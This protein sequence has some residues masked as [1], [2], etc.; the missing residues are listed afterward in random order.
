[1]FGIS[2]DQLLSWNGLVSTSQFPYP[3]RQLRIPPS[4]QVTVKQTQQTV[5]ANP[6][7]KPGCGNR[8][9]G[10][11]E[12]QA[13]D[14]FSAIRTKF[15]VSTA[16]LLAANQWPSINVFLAPGMKINIPPAGT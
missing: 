11:Y 10:T 2:V 13:G 1:M 4:A 7:G 14:S 5:V 3:G 6:V 9:A 16:A 15:C 8:P 12:V